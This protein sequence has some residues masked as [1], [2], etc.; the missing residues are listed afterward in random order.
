LSAGWEKVLDWTNSNQPDPDVFDYAAGFLLAGGKSTR[1]GRDKSLLTLE[2][3][4]L[5]ER[6]LRKLREVCPDVAI[7]GGAQELRFF[8]RVIKDKELECGP[9]GGIVTALEQ[10]TRE[11]NLFLAVDMPYVPVA[12][13][14]KLLCSAGGRHPVVLARAM[15]VV[16]PLCGVYS[17]RALGGLCAELRAGRLRVKD[18]VAAAGPVAYVQFPELDWFRNLNTPEEFRVASSATD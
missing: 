8:G 5:A 16:Q 9:L 3:E 1:M 6:G 4:T 10:S 15:G 12:A 14:R 17:R 18:A 11:W 2:G 7:A 13:L